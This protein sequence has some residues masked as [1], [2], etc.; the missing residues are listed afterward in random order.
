M[1][2]ILSLSNT[3]CIIHHTNLVVAV[4]HNPREVLANVVAHRVPARLVLWITVVRGLG[5]LV[6][7]VAL[8]EAGVVLKSVGT[9][10]VARSLR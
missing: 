3:L 1:Y 6:D 9:S 4:E 8:V 5:A 2:I 7:V 10:V